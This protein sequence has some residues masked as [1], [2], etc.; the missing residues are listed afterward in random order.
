[1]P[2]NNNSHNGSCRFNHKN[3]MKHATFI[4]VTVREAAH[5]SL[6]CWLDTLQVYT[7]RSSLIGCRISR[8]E[9]PK[10]LMILYLSPSLTWCPSLNQSK[11]TSGASSISHSNLTAFPTF[12]SMGTTLFV[13][14]GFP[15]WE[16]KV[17][18]QLEKWF[19]RP[20]EIGAGVYEVCDVPGTKW[21]TWFWK[22]AGKQGKTDILNR[23]SMK[24]QTCK[25]RVDE[26]GDMTEKWEL[27][28]TF[29]EDMKEAWG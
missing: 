23:R 19:W 16:K 1:M 11:L 21:N 5:S 24:V 20:T 7:P 26:Q 13:N 4:P 18:S 29:V 8:Q 2:N 3:G 28:Q 10:W 12:I 6:P 25:K 27:G 22:V 9:V 14:M 15:A 17:T